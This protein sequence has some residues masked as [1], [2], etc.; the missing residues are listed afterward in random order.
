MTLNLTQHKSTKE[1]LEAGVV[2]P[3]DKTKVQSL[4]T[5]TSV[6]T[7]NDIRDKAE[8]LAQIAYDHKAN[9]AMIGGAGYLMAPL[10]EALWAKGVKPLHSFTERR[11]TEKTL[12]DGSVE[13]GQVFVHIG[14]VEVI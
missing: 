7:P 13:K 11:A 1:Q 10:Q 5:F 12:P 2:E 14:W 3:T 6:P 4:L 9:A 8:A